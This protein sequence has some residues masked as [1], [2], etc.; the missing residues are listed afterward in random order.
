MLCHKE[1]FLDTNYDTNYMSET[2]VSV[3][4]LP[5]KWFKKVVCGLMKSFF[6]FFLDA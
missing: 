5:I 6:R 3:G 2:Y 4:S 1:E